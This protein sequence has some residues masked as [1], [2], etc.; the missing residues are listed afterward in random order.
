[1]ARGWQIPK[2]TPTRIVGA[3]LMVLFF[4]ACG[5]AVALLIGGATKIKHAFAYGVGWQGFL[6][7]YLGSPYRAANIKMKKKTA[8]AQGSP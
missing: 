2:L 5:G 8:K 4:V 7:G 3:L 6:G 1:M